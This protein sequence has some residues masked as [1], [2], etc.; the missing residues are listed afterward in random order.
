MG[1]QVPGISTSSPTVTIQ[2]RLYPYIGTIALVVGSSL[3]FH[4]ADSTDSS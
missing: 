3:Y 4:D 1:S 2:A